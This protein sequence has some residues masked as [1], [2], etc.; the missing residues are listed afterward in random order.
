MDINLN[1]F[2]NDYLYIISGIIILILVLFYFFMNNNSIDNISYTDKISIKNSLIPEGGR[3]VFAE[4]YF[5]KCEV[6]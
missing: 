3:G 6:I 1:E 4:K 5:K 2:N